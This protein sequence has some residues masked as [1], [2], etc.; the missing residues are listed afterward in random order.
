MKTS[1]RKQGIVFRIIQAIFFCIM[2]SGA[3]V[4]QNHIDPGLAIIYAGFAGLFLTWIWNW[5]HNG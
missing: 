3:F 1:I 5:I 4:T 2:V